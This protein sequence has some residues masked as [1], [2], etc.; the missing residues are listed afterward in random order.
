[1]SRTP[2]D[3]RLRDLSPFADC[4]ARERRVVAPAITLTTIASGDVLIRQGGSD[5]HLMVV[6]DGTATVTRDGHVV[7]EVS[8]GDVVGEM[9]ALVD[10]PRTATV[11]ATSAMTLATFSTDSF[12]VVFDECPTIAAAV[13]R[14]AIQRLAPAA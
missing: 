14:T 7:A 8:R 9:A 12:A 5:R 1:M 11:T 3:P 2:I 4:T 6:V 13:L 10:A